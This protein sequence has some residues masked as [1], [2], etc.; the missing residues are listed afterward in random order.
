VTGRALFA[1]TASGCRATI[2][3][4]IDDGVDGLVDPARQLGDLARYAKTGKVPV[5]EG[6]QAAATAMGWVGS[7]C[8]EH[9]PR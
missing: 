6:M 7:L 5:A 4:S 2:T 9:A 8:P 3:M 1:C